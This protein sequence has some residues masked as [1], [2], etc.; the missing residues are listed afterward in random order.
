MNRLNGLAPLSGVY[1]PMTMSQEAHDAIVEWRD[2]HEDEIAYAGDNGAP[3]GSIRNREIDDLLQ[4]R[5]LFNIAKIPP[6]VLSVQLGNM[7]NNAICPKKWS[8]LKSP[9]NKKPPP[10]NTL[11]NNTR[12]WIEKTLSI[13]LYTYC[14]Q[15]FSYTIN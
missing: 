12:V 11:K 13:G 5:I 6:H 14:I 9:E 15:L 3:A 10:E 8:N 7:L 4:D 1:K 2:N